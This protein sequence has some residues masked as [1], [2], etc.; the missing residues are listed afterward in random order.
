MLDL[1]VFNDPDG[2][3]IARLAGEL[4][5]AEVADLTESLQESAT[6]ESACLAIDL[7]EL[8]LLDSSGLAALIHLTN[9]ARLTGGKLVLVSPSPFVSGVFRTTR[10]D[11][12]FD[13]AADMGEARR[14]L[15]EP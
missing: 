13:I 7:A 5:G 3:V 8:G 11:R 9:R 4:V 2:V 12:W 6:G 14:L 10:L 15:S 1:Q